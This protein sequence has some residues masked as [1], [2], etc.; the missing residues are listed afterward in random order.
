MKFKIK[1]LQDRPVNLEISGSEEWLKP[2]YDSFA[3]GGTPGNL[4]ASLSMTKDLAGFVQVT[5]NVKFTPNLDC[6]RCSE[7]IPWPIDETV[8]AVYRPAT[9]EDSGGREINLSKNEL[10]HYLIENGSIDLE[11]LLNDVVHTAIPLQTVRTSEDG[12]TCTI[13]GINV[14]E[15]RVYG[16]GKDEKQSPFAVLKKLKT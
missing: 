10:D 6:S 9:G 14:G 4:V 3:N 8:E 7:S 16:E 12:T 1:D 15:D 13:C 2:V 5:G 11:V